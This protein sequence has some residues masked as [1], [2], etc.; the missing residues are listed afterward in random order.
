[1]SLAT[2]I[3]VPDGM[4]IGRFVCTGLEL[5]EGR[6]VFGFQAPSKTRN[7]RVY[8]LTF[9]PIT[10][11]CFCS[12]EAFKMNYASRTGK[13]IYGGM[14]TDRPWQQM[15]WHCQR[16]KAWVGRHHKEMDMTRETLKQV[17]ELERN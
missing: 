7:G 14:T 1:M 13:L 11:E 9:D 15:C 4:R 6:Y 5:L 3:D 8:L 12:C 2:T 16:V 10:N 17:Y